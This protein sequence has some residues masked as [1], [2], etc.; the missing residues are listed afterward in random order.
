MKWLNTAF[1]C[2][3]FDHSGLFGRKSLPKYKPPL[4]AI[5]Q[6]IGTQKLSD[7]YSDIHSA[8]MPPPM[9]KILYTFKLVTEIL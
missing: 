1:I 9:L 2:V 7:N 3:Y 8:S 5:P 4:A 6:D